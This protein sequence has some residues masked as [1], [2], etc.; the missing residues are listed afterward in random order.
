MFACHLEQ[1]GARLATDREVFE[2]L[3]LVPVPGNKYP[4][5][6]EVISAWRS[7]VK[8]RPVLFLTIWANIDIS[9]S[10]TIRSMGYTSVRLWYNDDKNYIELSI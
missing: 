10:E 7:G 4:T 5:K 3:N 6:T 8:F 9:R 2:V 1:H